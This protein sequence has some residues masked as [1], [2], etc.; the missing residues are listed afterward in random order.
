M[1]DD[2]IQSIIQNRKPLVDG[3]AGLEVVSILEA[4]QKSI[5][6]GGKEIKL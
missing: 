4:A 5:S 2:F 1:A 3:Y 6:L